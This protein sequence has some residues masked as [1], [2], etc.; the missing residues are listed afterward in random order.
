MNLIVNAELTGNCFFKGDARVPGRP[1]HTREA[2]RYLC[3]G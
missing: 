3:L 1:G 2:T